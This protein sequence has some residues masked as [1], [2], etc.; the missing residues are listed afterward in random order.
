M[1]LFFW[2]LIVVISGALE[3]H[4]NAL[5]GG[6]VAFGAIVAFVLAVA[7][8]SFPVQAGIWVLVTLVSTLT[9]RPLALKRFSKRPPGD[10]LA[11]TT[12][13]M[14]GMTGTVLA[15]VGDEAHPGKVL[16]RGESWSAVSEGAVL[17]P[18]T[19]IEVTLVRG[20]TLWVRPTA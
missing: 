8:V 11:P 17:A 18:E 2:L 10:L 5:A 16:V 15:T 13:M 3:L 9:L 7:H 12:S 14:T 20:T 1:A 19:P 4:T 6:F